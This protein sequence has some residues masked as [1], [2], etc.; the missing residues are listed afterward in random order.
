MWNPRY[1]F[2][3]YSYCHP[4]FGYKLNWSSQN[5]IRVNEQNIPNQ[6]K[7]FVVVANHQVIKSL[8]LHVVQFFLNYSVI[9]KN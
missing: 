7:F 3:L 1:F 5:S 4:N 9:W 6:T 8:L 2:Q